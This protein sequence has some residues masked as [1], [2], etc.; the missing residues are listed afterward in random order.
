MGAR[1]DALNHL[2]KAREFLEAAG[3]ELEWATRMVDAARD[4]TGS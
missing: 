4:V 3:L 1:D 2:R